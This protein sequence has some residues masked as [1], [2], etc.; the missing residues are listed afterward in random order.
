MYDK[1]QLF[2]SLA[3]A[4]PSCWCLKRHSG[5]T[6]IA[7]NCLWHAVGLFLWLGMATGILGSCT[8]SWVF[9][10]WWFSLWLSLLGLGSWWPLL[11]LRFRL[12]CCFCCWDSGWP[13]AF[14][15]EIQVGLLLLVTGIQVGLLLL[16]PSFRLARCFW[17][18]DSCWPV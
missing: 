12:A 17:R 18:W 14:V 13:V 16:S 7:V 10:H 11:S 15:A 6:Y 8:C 2:V 1:G 4:E 3:T 5:G 9:G